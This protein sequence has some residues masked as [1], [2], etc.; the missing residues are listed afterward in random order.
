VPNPRWDLY[1]VGLPL[2]P[3]NL[4]EPLIPLDSTLE[5]RFLE[6]VFFAP[7]EDRASPQKTY[8]ASQALCNL[9]RWLSPMGILSGYL[10]TGGPE[11]PAGREAFCALRPLNLQFPCHP[12]PRGSPPL[13]LSLNTKLMGDS[14]EE[15]S[16]KPLRHL[17]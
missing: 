7:E 8:L 14:M 10:G 17:L 5:T 4:R 3:A 6:F 2:H 12:F 15:S 1:L 16:G 11:W 9:F 13:F